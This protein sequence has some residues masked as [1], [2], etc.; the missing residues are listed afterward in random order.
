MCQLL[1]LSSSDPIRL[2][3]G[4]ESFA[5]RGSEAGGNPDGWGV[6]YFEDAD[7]MLLREP[8]PAA[9]S[10]MVQF[11]NRHAPR[12]N[13][14]VSHVRRATQGERR[15][16]NTQPFQRVLGGRTHVFA[17]NG[18]VPPASIPESSCW[19]LPQ[20]ETDSEQLFCLLLG[21]LEP[22]WSGGGIPALAQRREV[23]KRFAGEILERGGANFLYS[24]G[25]N[26]FAHGH[27][28]TL[29]GDAV[30]DKPGLYVN[31][32]T[33]KAGSDMAI[34]CEGLSSEGSC[35]YQAL[36][37]TQPLH[38]GDWVALQAG[39]IACFEQGLRIR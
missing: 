12:S 11:L 33:S 32:Y 21:R 13:L 37:A 3:F 5:M 4:W 29:P 6:A 20:G 19:L 17:H 2:K 14:I 26:L 35:S 39:E 9:E 7:V 38:Q 34:P 23:V 28:Q 16:A 15:L 10:P 1:G 22:L 30:S 31:L 18:F 24:D 8:V 36:V 25:I 27:R